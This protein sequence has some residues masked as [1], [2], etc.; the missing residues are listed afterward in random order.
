M[1]LIA[2]EEV[3]FERAELAF[4]EVAIDAARRLAHL[5][6]R[7]ENARRHELRDAFGL[8]HETAA[9]LGHG[10]RRAEIRGR[11]VL[12]P[13]EAVGMADEPAHG[14]LLEAAGAVPRSLIIGVKDIAL[15]VEAHAPGRAHAACRRNE[16][17]RRR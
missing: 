15:G 1:R 12:V 14:D 11:R 10:R 3:L 13:L 5:L 17:A 8:S 9:A 4:G 6:I 16:L 7:E 2:D